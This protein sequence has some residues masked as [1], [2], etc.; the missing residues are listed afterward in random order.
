MEGVHARS[1]TAE[2]EYGGSKV[3]HGATEAARTGNL[4][5]K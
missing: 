4:L 5:V 2:N 1:L 3:S